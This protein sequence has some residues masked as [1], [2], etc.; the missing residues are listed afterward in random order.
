MVTAH[1]CFADR[2]D[3]VAGESAPATDLDRQSEPGQ[4]GDPAQAAR[5]VNGAGPGTVGIHGRDRDNGVVALVERGLDQWQAEALPSHPGIVGTGPSLPVRV[6]NLM[7][8]QPI[9]QAVTSR[10]QVTAAVPRRPSPGH[11]RLK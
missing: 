5:P 11:G 1:R 6:D 7:P 2:S 3:G 4:R 9:R 10:H 8:Q